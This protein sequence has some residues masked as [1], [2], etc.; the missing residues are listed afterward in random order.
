MKFATKYLQ[1]Q[2]YA[3]RRRLRSSAKHN[4]RSFEKAD[5]ILGEIREYLSDVHIQFD[6][7][8]SLGHAGGKH[9]HIVSL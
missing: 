6:V 2:W 3:I 5:Q 1:E 7:V 9:K 8:A 4:T